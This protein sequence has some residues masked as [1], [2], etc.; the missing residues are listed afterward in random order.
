MSFHMKNAFARRALAAAAIPLFALFAS[1]AHADWGGLRY[2]AF[3]D[4]EITVASGPG[5]DPALTDFL[6]PFTG[7]YTIA[8]GGINS[9]GAGPFAYRLQ[10]TAVPEPEIALLFGAGLGAIAWTR[11]RARGRSLRR[12]E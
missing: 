5:G 10:V 9:D 3:A 12:P 6:L 2:L 7:D 4:D 8:L 1:V 11:R